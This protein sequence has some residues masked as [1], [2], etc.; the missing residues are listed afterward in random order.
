MHV[1]VQK[2]TDEALLRDACDATRKPG[3]TPSTMTLAKAYQCQHSPA[4]T[5]LFKVRLE[6]IPTFVSVHLVRH[7]ATGQCHFVES[8]REDRGGE[9]ADRLTPVNH[10]MLL[11]AQHL[12]DM[13][14]DRLCYNAHLQTVGIFSRIRNAVRTVDPALAENMVPKCVRMGFCPEL[15]ACKPGPVSV[16]RSYAHTSFVRERAKID[17]ALQHR[18][19]EDSHG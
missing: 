17:R 2:L 12:M 9:A 13:A 4:R 18:L 14:G 8:N 6:G 1:T 15:R 11:N 10:L 7:S 19:T 16:I 3:L 5:Q